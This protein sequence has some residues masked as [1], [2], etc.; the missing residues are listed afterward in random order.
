MSEPALL[1]ASLPPLTPGQNVLAQPIGTSLV[2][3]GVVCDR[4]KLDTG[5][6]EISAEREIVLRSGA[7]S[8]TLTQAGK[9][10][11][12]GEYV[13]SRSRGVNKIKGGS[14]QIN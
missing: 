12:D 5:S 4:Q 10:I 14:V 6:C 9:V 3:L 11:I 2:I 1:I 8:L 7:A 13:L